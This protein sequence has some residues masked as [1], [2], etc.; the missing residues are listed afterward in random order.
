VLQDGTS[1]F[2]N[3]VHVA[4]SEWNKLSSKCGNNLPDLLLSIGTGSL[5][6]A[7]AGMKDKLD[8][9]FNPSRTISQTAPETSL[10]PDE[11]WLIFLKREPQKTDSREKPGLTRFRRINLSLD[12]QDDPE[13]SPRRVLDGLQNAASASLVPPRIQ[14][15]VKSIANRLIASSFYFHLEHIEKHPDSGSLYYI[16]KGRLNKRFRPARY[17]VDWIC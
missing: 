4:A 6:K 16:C 11:A 9:V 1:S 3:P 8:K 12:Y 13:L 2:N 10:D 5:P 14:K 15:D 7:E 17:L